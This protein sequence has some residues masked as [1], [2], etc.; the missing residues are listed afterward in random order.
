MVKALKSGGRIVLEDD[1]HES[2]ILYPEPSG[3]KELWSAYMQSYIEVGNDPFIGRKL[4]KL[5]LDQGIKNISND[6]V[7]FGDCAGTETFDLFTSNLMEVISTSYSVMISAKLISDSDYKSAMANIRTWG[8]LPHA[9]LWYN[10]N[11][12]IGIK[13]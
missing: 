2:M 9:S 3:F 12:A 10:I 8:A 13:G 1:D 6:I 5:L 11:V 4:P 7:F